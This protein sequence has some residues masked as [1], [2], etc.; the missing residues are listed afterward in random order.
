MPGLLN[1]YKKI[2]KYR[3]SAVT[4]S[5]MKQLCRKTMPVEYYNREIGKDRQSAASQQCIKQQCRNRQ[6]GRGEGND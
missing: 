1:S 2:W 4:E 6:T 5:C 3:Q